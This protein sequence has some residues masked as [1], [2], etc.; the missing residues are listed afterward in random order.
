MPSRPSSGERFTIRLW[1][2]RTRGEQ[3][4]PA[5]DASVMTLVVDDS[6]SESPVTMR[7]RMVSARS[8]FRRVAAGTHRIGI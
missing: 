1:E 8:S 5:Y 2:D 6:F 4:V 3:W 7:S